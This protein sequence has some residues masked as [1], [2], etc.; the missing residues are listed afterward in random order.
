MPLSSLRSEIRGVPGVLLIKLWNYIS[1]YVIIK[2]TGDYGE[3]LLNQ[4]AL[5]NL[6]LWDVQRISSNELIAKIS[7]GHFFKIARLARKTRCRIYVL[8]RIG[9]YFLINKL[10]KRKAFILGALLFVAAVYV[11]SSFIWSIEVKCPDDD[12]KNSVINDLRQWGLTEGTF[13]Y[14]LD[15]KYYLNK[16]LAKYKDV[17]WA[18]L[19]VRGTKILVEIVEKQLPPELEQ[20]TPCDIIASKDGVI[21]EIILLRG[22]ALVE[23][24]QTVSAGDV[25]ITGRVVLNLDQPDDEV[26]NILL[27]HAQGIA[28]ARVWY[29]RAVRVPLVKTQEVPTGNTKKTISFQ[30]G[31]HILNL[32]L[33]DINYALV[34][35]EILKEFR[36]LPQNIG[37][38][39]LSVVQYHEMEIVKEFLGIE[40]ASKEAETQLLSQLEDIVNGKIIHKKMEYMLDDDEKS[41]IG[42]LIIEVVEDISQKRQIN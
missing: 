36:L 12:L 24:G 1:G 34:K 25:L 23:P 3:R 31:D 38:L 26:E 9:L 20:N 11:L 15:K 14:G 22:E 6:Y 4:A 39:G 28:K 18:E 41:V 29:Q 5:N 7:V 33:G 42:S 21:E 37:K 19:E 10:R 40:E 30:I 32:Q 17:A 27:V 16:I 35:K 2:I 8:E 13:K